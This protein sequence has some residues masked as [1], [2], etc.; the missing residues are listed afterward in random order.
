MTLADE[1]RQVACAR[2]DPHH[3]R[4]VA[5]LIRKV[6]GLRELPA[7]Q[8]A[9]TDP[10]AQYQA[11]NEVIEDAVGRLAT[12]DGQAAR[13]LLGMT[14]QTS[15]AI[16]P[17]RQR[18]AGS[19]YRVSWE[20]FR[21]EPQK[22]L[23]ERI[24]NE[25]RPARYTL[26]TSPEVIACKPGTELEHELI[27]YIRNGKPDRARHLGYS[28]VTTKNILLALRD[29][30]CRTRLLMA[31][32]IGVQSG[33]QRRRI[34]AAIDDILNVE[35]AGC[36][37]LVDVRFYSTPPSLRGCRFGER[38]VLG[39]YTY[40]DDMGLDIDAPEQI[41]TWGHDNALV[42]ADTRTQQGAWLALWFEREFDRL[43]EHRKTGSD[44]TCPPSAEQ[45]AAHPGAAL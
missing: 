26:P 3:E 35:F 10:S 36:R 37:D 2:A 15:T 12:D 33:F 38:I 25:I 18:I 17:V 11:I 45:S 40:R 41:A 27:E 32:P 9:G 31:H 4:K 29:V 5:D 6:P 21:R 42:M 19:I 39:W 34:Q 24:S 13:A 7:V 20:T 30:G 1:I 23:L 44:P 22:R 8:A 28:C 43:W 16:W 14:E